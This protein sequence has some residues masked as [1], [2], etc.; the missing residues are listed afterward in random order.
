MVRYDA[1]KAKISL[2]VGVGRHDLGPYTN[3]E[4]D[5]GMG[6]ERWLQQVATPTQI[7]MANEARVTSLS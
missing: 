2:G 6:T 7:A 1:G 3:P 4:A 5:P